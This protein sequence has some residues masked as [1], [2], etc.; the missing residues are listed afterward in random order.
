[1]NLQKIHFDDLTVIEL[2]GSRATNA[3]QSITK[4]QHEI[5]KIFD[6]HK[7]GRRKKITES[8]LVEIYVALKGDNYIPKIMEINNIHPTSKNYTTITYHYLNQTPE[9][10]YVLKARVRN[11]FAGAVGRLIM[12]GSMKAITAINLDKLDK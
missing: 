6:P 10:K 1:M 5:L 7:R 4:G 3:Y 12:K 11:Y 2:S 9:W 8:V